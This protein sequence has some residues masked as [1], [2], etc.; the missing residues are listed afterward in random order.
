MK[1]GLATIALRRHDVFHV[2]D[3]AAQ[4]GFQG[5]EIWG[6]PPH[7]PEE[8]DEDHTRRIKDRLR[9]NGLKASMFGSYANPAAPDYEQK[10]ED[11]LKIAKLLCVRK[12]RVWAGNKE[13][14]EADEELWDHVAK[15]LHEFALRAE[16]AGITLAIEM[17]CGTLCATAEGCIRVIEDSES[18][19]LKLNYQVAD[20]RNPDYERVIGMVGDYVVNV[21]AQNHRPSPREPDKLEL[22]LIQEGLVDYD[23]ALS[24]LGEHGFKGFVEVEF[25]KGEQESE[26]A[27]LDALKRDAAYLKELTAKYT[28]CSL[29]S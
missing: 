19:N 6:G 8:F 10:A 11:A 14:H 23:R 3:L 24:L 20:P 1:A 27:M 13:P 9:A 16:D 12:I 29:S 28:A 18:P 26:E 21:H 7:T 22:C 2:I 5:V 15:S 4:A 25:L 17:H